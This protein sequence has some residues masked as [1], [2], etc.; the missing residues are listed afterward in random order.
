MKSFPIVCLDGS[1][2]GFDAYIRL[3]KCM[4][5]VMGVAIV[6]VNHMTRVPTQLHEI[7]RRFTSCGQ[8]MF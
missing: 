3:L 4:P 1:A 2:G 6:I 7:L 8:S 5:A